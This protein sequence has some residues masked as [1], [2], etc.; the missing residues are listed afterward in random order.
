MGEINLRPHHLKVVL[1]YF[2]DTEQQRQEFLDVCRR[3]YGEGFV[4]G[5]V[6]MFTEI[7]AGGLI[8]IIS[9]EDDICHIPCKFL[10][11]CKDGNYTPLVDAVFGSDGS[12]GFITPED[13]DRFAVKKMGITVGL[14]YFFG[15]DEDPEKQDI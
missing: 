6:R 4:E 15:P 8:R 11:S 1:Q 14:T 9:G 7:E 13:A 5:A 12:K 3:E 10:E 2:S